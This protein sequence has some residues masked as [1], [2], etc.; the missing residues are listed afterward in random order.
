MGGLVIVNPKAD[1]GR[2][3]RT[4]GGVRSVFE[5]RLGAM[6]VAFTSGPGHAIGLAR[7][8]ARQG[9]SPIV[10][11][12]GD[13]T[14]HEVVNGVLDSGASA[15]VGYVGHGT[16][17]DF[18]RTLG[19]EHRLDAY[20]EAIARGRERRVDAGR[21]RYRDRDGAD[22][23]RWF[24][25]V[26]SAGLGGLVDQRIAHTTRAL[27]NRAAYLLASLGALGACRRGR[28]RCRASLGG[29]ARDRSLSAYMIAVCNGRFFGGGM[30]V[31]PM[32]K[33]DDGRFEVVSMDAPNKMAFAA[34]SR[35]IYGGTHLNAPGVDHFACDRIAID[36]ENVDARDVF[37][38]D[39][40][41]EPLGG[42][43]VE[44]ELVPQA[45]RILS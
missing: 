7:Q 45:V 15:A 24:L 17:G 34:Y 4:F 39:V 31:A 9:I 20:V 2:A 23:T 8:A 26:L 28:L 22:Q 25:N 32:A 37:L 27:G 43:P 35:R 29:E 1:G 42:L 18:R 30:N 40:D 14:L 41:G 44:I 13:G 19:L 38:L 11:V 3:G 12:G 10:A 21:V 16:G 5:R 36:L 6:E 33:P